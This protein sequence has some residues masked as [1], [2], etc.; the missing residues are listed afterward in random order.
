[1]E[2]VMPYEMT[3]ADIDAEA[4]WNAM[5]DRLVAWGYPPS[6]IKA[7]QDPFYYVLGLRDGQVFLFSEACPNG[8]WVWLKVD[9]WMAPEEAS[10]YPF[11][12]GVDVR[13]ADIVWCA[14]AP[15]GS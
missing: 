3:Q 9:F 15:W 12:R 4:E 2:Q 5:Q 11:E 10:I 7:C 8:E 6:L 14:D 13:V 1:M